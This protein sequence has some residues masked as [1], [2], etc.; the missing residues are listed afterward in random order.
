MKSNDMYVCV[1]IY[2]HICVC[3]YM[4]MYVYMYIRVVSRLGFP[5]KHSQIVAYMR[6]LEHTNSTQTAVLEA[7]PTAAYLYVGQFQT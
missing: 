5:P 4:Y 6:P 3:M 2:T 1:H 7:A